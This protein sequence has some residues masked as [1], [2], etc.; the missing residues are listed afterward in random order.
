MRIMYRYWDNVGGD[1]LAAALDAAHVNARFII[2]GQIAGYNSGG[3]P[4]Y[5]LHQIFAKS[6]TLTGFLFSRLAPKYQ[7][8][9]Y[10]VVPALVAEG[11]IKH[12]EHVWNGLDKVGDAMAAVQKGTNKAKAVIHV[13]EDE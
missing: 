9:F 10:E 11:K 7:N 5:N 8:G 6:L 3:A 2:C 12:R 1:T 4:V 13:A